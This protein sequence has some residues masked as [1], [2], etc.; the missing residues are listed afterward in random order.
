M[1]PYTGLLHGTSKLLS[2][3]NAAVVSPLLFPVPQFLLLLLL[4]PPGSTAYTVSKLGRTTASHAYLTCCCQAWCCAQLRVRN[5][6]APADSI[7]VEKAV[8]LSEGGKLPHMPSRNFLQQCLP[9]VCRSPAAKVQPAVH[10]YEVAAWCMQRF[11]IVLVSAAA[12]C[13]CP[14]RQSSTQQGRGWLNS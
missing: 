5:Q 2:A 12:D 6:Q 10:I 14:T 8:V 13:D 9:A 1:D 7:A 11:E 4:I 3:A